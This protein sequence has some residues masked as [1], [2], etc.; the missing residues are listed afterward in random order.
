MDQKPK[1][2]DLSFKKKS[3]EIDL[4]PSLG[5]AKPKLPPRQSKP[6]LRQSQIK[7]D[8]FNPET[9]K[10]LEKMVQDW[11]AKQHQPRVIHTST[12]T[13]LRA[14]PKRS[15]KEF[16]REEYETDSLVFEL[17]PHT[18]IPGNPLHW[19]TKHQDYECKECE[20]DPK[21]GQKNEEINETKSDYYCELCNH[22]AKTPFCKRCNKESATRST[23]RKWRSKGK[24]KEENMKEEVEHHVY[25]SLLGGYLSMHHPSREAA[26]A[27]IDKYH[28][29]Q[30][31]PVLSRRKEPLQIVTVPKK[32][33]SEEI[34]TLEP[35]KHAGVKEAQRKFLERATAKIEKEKAKLHAA[36]KL[37]EESEEE[38]IESS[39]EKQ[40]ERI[41]AK[42]NKWKP[43]RSIRDEVAKEMGLHK[44][45]GALGG[46][47]YEE[48]Q[49][50]ERNCGHCNGTG[51]HGDFP[52][53]NCKGKGVIP[54]FTQ[55]KGPSYLER[56]AARH[57]PEVKAYRQTMGLE[58]NISE[59][60]EDTLHNK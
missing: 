18:D 33:I 24:P 57:Q 13:V 6:I 5:E 27:S 14:R 53:V 55:I 42:L 36:G 3:D 56:W 40:R 43:S 34:A 11:K 59:T 28:S 50:G 48:D 46:T 17:C 58:E 44:V 47:Y 22:A 37:K 16:H 25:S 38:K 2:L 10:K 49:I 20:K 12:Y 15:F 31:D 54:T 7:E 30:H 52:C 39:K 4:N 35:P 29:S 9:L 23:W 8:D 45:K 60:I 19:C 51:H 26:Q 1:K 41:R 32:K 21:H